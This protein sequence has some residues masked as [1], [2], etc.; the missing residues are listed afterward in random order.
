MFWF[1]FDFTL[2]HRKQGEPPQQYLTAPVKI[3]ILVIFG[4]S[5]PIIKLWEFTTVQVQL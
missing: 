4:S 5:N 1:L 3:I 2:A